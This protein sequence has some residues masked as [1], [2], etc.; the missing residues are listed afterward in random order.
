MPPRIASIHAGLR[1]GVPLLCPSSSLQTP[2]RALNPGVQI[3]KS[4]TKARGRSSRITG[5]PSRCTIWRNFAG[6]MLRYSLA[7]LKRKSRRAELSRLVIRCSCLPINLLHPRPLARPDVATRRATG[8]LSYRSG[9]PS[10][11]ASLS[12][13]FFYSCRHH[14]HL[15]HTGKPEVCF[16]SSPRRSIVLIERT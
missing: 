13:V 4:C 16:L 7:G 8:D 1:D 11:T 9:L 12:A 10:C 2:L 14:F 3:A 6:E 5:K 15:N